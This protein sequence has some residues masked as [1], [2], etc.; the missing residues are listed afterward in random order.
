[1]RDMA[2]S[3]ALCEKD[4]RMAT[5]TIPNAVAGGALAPDP[6]SDDRTGGVLSEM[7]GVSALVLLG[8]PCAYCRAY[9]DAQLDACPICGCSERLWPGKRSCP[10]I[11]PRTVHSHVA[12]C[13]DIGH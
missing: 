2:C 3:R 5:R 11:Q 10:V 4:G 1:M 6:R 8:L 7:H 13:S 9:Y 12:Q